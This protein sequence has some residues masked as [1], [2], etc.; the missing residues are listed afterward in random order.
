MFAKVAWIDVESFEEEMRQPICRRKTTLCG[1]LGERCCCLLQFMLCDFKSSVKYG[2]VYRLS[3]HL[4]KAQIKK[5]SGDA[6]MFYYIVD[7][8]AFCGVGA[9]V[10]KSFAHDVAGGTVRVESRSTTPRLLTCAG[11]LFGTLRLAIM[12]SRILAPKRPSPS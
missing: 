2:L 5:P 7:V 3:V 9:D 11:M 1:N 10:G 6:Y 4:L 8:Y 12:Q